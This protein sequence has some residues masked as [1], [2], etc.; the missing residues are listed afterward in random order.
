M[1]NSLLLSA[2]YYHCQNNPLLILSRGK[3]SSKHQV[4]QY[5][6]AAKLRFEIH[7]GMSSKAACT[8]II[9]MG[10]ADPRHDLEILELGVDNNFEVEKLKKHLD[11]LNPLL[12]EK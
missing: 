8:F 6:L 2:M 9:K 7:R 12:G 1:N 11:N 10:P 3:T 5:D 4:W